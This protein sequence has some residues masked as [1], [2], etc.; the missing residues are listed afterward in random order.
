MRAAVDATFIHLGINVVYT[1]EGGSPIMVRAL[2][3]RP[4]EIATFGDT[5]LHTETAIF[6]V[7]T[8]EVE[9][10]RPGDRITLG[11]T[12]YIIQG[13]PERRDPDRLVWTIDTRP[14]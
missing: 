13:E 8:S 9:E 2:A 12:I 6:E 4:D 3:R 7:R 11:D 14:L 1:P 10:P 5:R